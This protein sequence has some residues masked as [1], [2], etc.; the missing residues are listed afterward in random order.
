[1]LAP[2]LLSSSSEKDR[3]GGAPRSSIGRDRIAGSCRRAGP[4]YPGREASGEE[5]NDP[6]M[7]PDGPGVSAVRHKGRKETSGGGS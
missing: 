1:M 3:L 4:E 5:Q 6:R 2:S 7:D